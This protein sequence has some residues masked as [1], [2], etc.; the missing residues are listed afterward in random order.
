MSDPARLP[1]TLE[2]FFGMPED[3]RFHEFIG[4]EIVEKTAPSAEHGDAQA[5]V[6]APVRSRYHGPPG[7]GRGGWWIATEVEVQLSSGEIVRPDVL[8]WRREFLPERPT[9]TPVRAR[10]DWICEVVSPSRPNDDTV[11]KLRLYHHNAVPHYWIVDPRDATLT[12]H[13]WT[14]EGYLNVLRAERTETVHPEPFPELAFF[15]GSL[16]G[17][18]P[19]AVK[20]R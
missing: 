19:P 16:F 14:D 5:G 3:E 17:D 6:V 11:T 1:G 13:R 2:A 10:P 9:G 15:V 20:D 8:G 18:E 7:A 12:V 4:G